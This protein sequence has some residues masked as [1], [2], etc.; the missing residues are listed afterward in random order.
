MPYGDLQS[1][2]PVV[3][4]AVERINRLLS[5]NALWGGRTWKS[6]DG[7]T[8]GKIK[9]FRVFWWPF[10]HNAHHII[11]VGTLWR[12]IEMV[13]NEAAPNSG[14]MLNLV[15]GILLE[16]P[17]NLNDQCNM[18][19]LPNKIKDS[20]RLGLP[21]HL[22]EKYRSHTDYQNQVAKFVYA[23]FPPEFKSLAAT[24]KTE[25]HSKEQEDPKV[26]AILEGISKATYEAILAVGA[27]TATRGDDV[28]LDSVSKQIG[29]IA[30]KILS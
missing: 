19:V 23:K 25:D 10:S 18:I 24:V 12:A 11:P 7:K 17:Y 16:E 9:P 5:K 26:R 27:A 13:T 3:L 30:S 15:I 4:G 20:I 28:T 29:Q 6:A 2:N 14:K 8:T 1:T 21:K 22:K